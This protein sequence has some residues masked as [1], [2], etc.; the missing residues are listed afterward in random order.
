MDASARGN[1]LQHGA[2]WALLP[3]KNPAIMSNIYSAVQKL[4]L[5]AMIYNCQNRQLW[6]IHT[7][8]SIIDKS[9]ASTKLQ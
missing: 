4:Q 1:I 3:A 6:V 5:Q 8:D 2:A 9:S 7:T